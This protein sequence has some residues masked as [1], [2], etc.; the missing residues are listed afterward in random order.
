MVNLGMMLFSLFVVMLLSMPVLVMAFIFKVS[1]LS[2]FT[3]QVLSQQ[4][5][6]FGLDEILDLTF[7]QSLGTFT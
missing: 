6:N 4:L 7:S 2:L 1:F 5:L 3:L